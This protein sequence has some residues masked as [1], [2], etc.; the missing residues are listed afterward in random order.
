[1]AFSIA[2][3]ERIGGPYKQANWCGLEGAETDVEGIPEATNGDRI[4]LDAIPRFPEVK[5]ALPVE[6][7]VYTN[8][9]QQLPYRG[10]KPI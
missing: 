3:G 9:L 10:R 2:G 4:P 7:P 5:S 8:Q 6:N 1:V